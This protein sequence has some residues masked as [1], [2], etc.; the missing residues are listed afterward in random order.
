MK[1]AQSPNNIKRL[2]KRGI[3]FGF[4]FFF[5]HSLVVFTD[6]IT[7]HTPETDVAVVPGCPLKKD[8]S[9]SP[10]LKTRLDRALELYREQKV[11]WIVVSSGITQKGIREADFMKKY[12]VENGVPADSIIADNNGFNSYMTARNYDSIR[13]VYGFRSFTLVTQFYHITR[14]KLAFL[15]FGLK[16]AGS[17]HGRRFF[18]QD[19]FGMVREF[20]AFY[21]YLVFPG[22]KL[23]KHKLPY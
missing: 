23:E 2:I 21:K 19:A 3:I 11:K 8:G 9:P 13:K 6:G 12:M 20:F 17:A 18:G 1:E 22:S 4:L 7:D 15:K 5:I 10:W 16:P 14:C